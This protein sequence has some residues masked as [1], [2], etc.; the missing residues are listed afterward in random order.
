[1]IHSPV[2]ARYDLG[3]IREAVAHAARG[4]RNGKIILTG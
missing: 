2:E 3:H 1:V 4:G